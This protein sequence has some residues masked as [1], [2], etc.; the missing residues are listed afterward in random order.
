[1]NDATQIKRGKRVR[2]S[3]GT[4]DV[5]ARIEVVHRCGDVTVE[6][7]FY[8]DANGR[9]VPGFIGGRVRLCAGD[10]RL[11]DCFAG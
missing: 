9:E 8:L 3:T 2:Y 7:T 5:H 10:F 4:S 1:M 6:P 11:V